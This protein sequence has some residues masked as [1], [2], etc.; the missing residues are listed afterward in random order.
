MAD[1]QTQIQGMINFTLGTEPAPTQAEVSQ[2]LTD[3]A[4]E[5][6]ERL[7]VGKPEALANFTTSTT[8]SDANGHPVESGLIIS[9]VRADGTSANNL[10]P[11][12]RITSDLRF[13][14]TDT[15]SLS[16]A[17][18]FNPVYHVLNAKLFVLPEPS[19]GTVNKAIVTTVPYPTL[20]YNH[21]LIDN[22]PGQYEY[23][24]VLYAAKKCLES[25]MAYYAGTEED[26]ELVQA[27]QPSLVTI[28]QNYNTAFGLMS[29]PP[30]QQPQ[31]PQ[32]G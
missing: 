7:S 20:A 12:T 21:D 8:I 14:A 25:I 10:E 27:I 29:P 32:Q 1:F 26:I 22:F 18:K 2:W 15:E 6:I 31:A 4:K 30:A 24:V 5:V 23:L 19:D 13:R 16:Y 9:V 28:E 3:G 11:C 17:S